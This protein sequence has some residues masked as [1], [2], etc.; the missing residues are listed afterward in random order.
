LR[1]VTLGAALLA[2]AATQPLPAECRPSWRLQETTPTLVGCAIVEAWVAKS[3]KEGFGITIALRRAT[4][5]TSCRARV[6]AASFAAG[7]YHAA[8]SRL[9]DPVVL[10]DE[11]TY[12]YLPFPFD[13]QAL[14]RESVDR[15]ELR[16]GIVTLEIAAGTA[17]H[18]AAKRWELVTAQEILPRH[19]HQGDRHCDD[20]PRAMRTAPVPPSM[21]GAGSIPPTV[22]V[23]G[24]SP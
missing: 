22:E 3:G 11:E 14:W 4:A 21:V 7:T 24:K 20:A 9:P 16:R 15:A 23:P 8:P 1:L 6:T 19:E 5:D 18:E 10:S 13:N 2:C 17:D 12:L